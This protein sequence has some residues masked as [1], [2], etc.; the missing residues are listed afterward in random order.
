MVGNLA[1]QLFQLSGADVLG[2]DISPFRAQL[3]RA[4]GIGNVIDSSRADLEEAVSEWSRGL[5]A[6]VTVESVGSAELILRSVGLTR[7]LGEVI[8]LG[9]PRRKVELN[10]SPYFWQAHMK[11]VRLKGALRC[12]F[13]P[14]H[15]RAYSRY[16]VAGDLHQILELMAASRLVVQ[17]LHTDTFAPD[18]CQEAYQH[19]QSAGDR[20]LGV[21]FD[22]TG[23]G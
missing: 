16:S 17:P 10:P 21:L 6:D 5:G 2:V 22:W 9:T 4:C 18:Q 20:A 1:A 19:I 14:L 11:G 12:L 3:A 13:Y 7:R 15:P 8:L 23:S